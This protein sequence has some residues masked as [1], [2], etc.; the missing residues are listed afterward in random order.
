MT[1]RDKNGR[2][3]PNPNPTSAQLKRRERDRKRKRKIKD[4]VQPPIQTAKP[5]INLVGFILDVSPSM[6]GIIDMAKQVFNNQVKEACATA[7]RENQETLITMTAFSSGVK[8]Y[9][10]NKP[11]KGFNPPVM[12]CVQSWATALEDAVVMTALE[13][14]AKGDDLERQG[15]DV[16]YLLYTI[17]D[18]KENG[19]LTYKHQLG[20]YVSEVW[21]EAGNWTLGFL[22]PEYAGAEYRRL[23]IPEGNFRFWETTQK[24]VQKDVVRNLSVGTQTYYAT[25]SAGGASTKSLFVDLSDVRDADFTDGNDVTNKFQSW[26]IEKESEIST[27]VNTKLANPNVAR[28]IGHNSYILGNAFYELTKKETIQPQ[29]QIAIQDKVTGKIIIGDEARRL[30]GMAGSGNFRADPLN[31]SKYKLFVQSTSPNRKL[32]RGTTLLYLKS[33]YATV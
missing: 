28:K 24:S 29:K 33:N 20:R 18:G 13:M 5:Q 32:V 8:I 19:S 11:T 16:A 31:L 1:R 30:A 25:R 9:V 21:N 10:R 17:T 2:F 4:Q 23:G 3:A 14:K 15:Y 6:G 27:F 12:P 22:G 7:E 26:K